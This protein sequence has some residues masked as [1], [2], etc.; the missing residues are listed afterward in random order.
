MAPSFSK[1]R[2]RKS[3]EGNSQDYTAR[4][5]QIWSKVKQYESR[6]FSFNSY[7]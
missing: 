4:K 5:G 6:T 1:M 7:T 3:R 2:E